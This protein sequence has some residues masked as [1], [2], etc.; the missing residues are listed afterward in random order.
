I[1]ADLAVYG[2][3]IVSA[4][5][6]QCRQAIGTAPREQLE[7]LFNHGI[8]EIGCRGEF[9]RP[10]FTG[11][12]GFEHLFGIEV[13]QQVILVIKGGKGMLV[14]RYNRANINHQALEGDVHPDNAAV[15]EGLRQRH[16][17]L[18]SRRE[19]IWQRADNRLGIFHGVAIPV[20][21][22]WIILGGRFAEG[23]DLTVIAVKKQPGL[24][25][26]AVVVG[27]DLVDDESRERGATELFDERLL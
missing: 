7:S 15:L 10:G 6:I 20:A 1:P 14:I 11:A 19:E 4:A 8:A 25:P 17:D 22:A 18:R 3:E 5:D 26:G 23:S 2:G 16:P 21:A 24:Y 12:G 13:R 9:G 27:A